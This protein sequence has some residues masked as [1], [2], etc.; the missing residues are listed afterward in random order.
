[1]ELLFRK[2]VELPNSYIPEKKM[3]HTKKIKRS[4]MQLQVTFFSLPN[5]IACRAQVST[6]KE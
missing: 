4:S 3:Q 1:M 5:F 2:K 6:P